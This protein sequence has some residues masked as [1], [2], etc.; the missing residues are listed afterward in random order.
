MGADIGCIFPLQL[1]Q[2]RVLF[3]DALAAIALLESSAHLLIRGREEHRTEKEDL[4]LKVEREKR[5]WE[6]CCRETEEA[7]LITGRLEVKRQKLIRENEELEGKLK[8]GE[9]LVAELIK[10]EPKGKGPEER[11]S[12]ESQE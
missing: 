7:Q 8:Q 1:E 11:G 6:R 9:A 12:C 3:Q 10:K 4:E 2:Y 5:S